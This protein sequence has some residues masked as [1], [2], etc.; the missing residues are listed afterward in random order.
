MVVRTSV[1]A[2]LDTCAGSAF[3]VWQCIEPD[4]E[5]LIRSFLIS[6]KKRA[7]TA[8]HSAFAQ[9]LEAGIAH[10]SQSLTAAHT[11]LSAGK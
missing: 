4:L 8:V 2:V 3:D 7:P 10:L 11:S 5:R 1:F 9:A 6:N